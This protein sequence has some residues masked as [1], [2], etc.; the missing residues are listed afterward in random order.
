MKRFSL[1]LLIATC[2]AQNIASAGFSSPISPAEDDPDTYLGILLGFG[3]NMQSGTATVD[4]SECLF[5]GGVG[6]GYTFGLTY[7]KQFIKDEDHFFHNWHYGG[8]LHLNS[9]NFAARYKEIQSEHFIGAAYSSFSVPVTYSH[10]ND[11]SLMS[12]G[13][14][15][16]ISYYPVEFLFAK[17]GLDAAV[18]FRSNSKHS[19]EIAER[20]ISLPNGEVVDVY[21]PHEQNPNRKLYSQTLQ[22]AAIKGINRFQVAIAPAVGGNIRLS[23]KLV[24][25]P[26]F[27]MHFPLSKVSNSNNFS[28]NNWRFNVEFRYNIARSYSIYRR[29]PQRKAPGIINRG[30]GGGN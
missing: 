19:V 17:I 5:S 22:D 10:T 29:E 9:G 15:P 16:F 30:R 27:S 3:Q 25:S 26:S 4:C 21:I 28:V 23:D 8:M 14:S 11:I 2:F 20:R 7:E 1:L 18:V 24:L 13:L 12:A 6:F